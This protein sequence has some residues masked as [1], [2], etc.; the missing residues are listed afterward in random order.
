MIDDPSDRPLDD[1]A[2]EGPLDWIDRFPRSLFA[3][4]ALCVLAIFAAG[5]LV[6]CAVT[7]GA[8][9]LGHRP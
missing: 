3:C 9:A 4:L 6:G 2:P 1:E 8:V 7:L 5:S